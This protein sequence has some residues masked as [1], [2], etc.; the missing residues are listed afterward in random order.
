MWFVALL[1]LNHSLDFVLSTGYECRCDELAGNG[2][3]DPK[4]EHF[5]WD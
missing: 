2:L 1:K 3:D 5:S 4:G